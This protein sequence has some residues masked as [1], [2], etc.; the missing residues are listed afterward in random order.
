VCQVLYAL[1]SSYKNPVSFIFYIYVPNLHLELYFT[2]ICSLCH[3][4]FPLV[5]GSCAVTWCDTFVILS[6][7]DPAPLM[8][9]NLL[10]HLC[11]CQAYSLDLK[12]HIVYQKYSLK[13][14]INDIVTDLDVSHRTVEQVLKMWWDTGEVVPKVPGKKKKRIRVMLG[15]EMEVQNTYQINMSPTLSFPPH[16][17]F[18]VALVQHY[19]DLYLNELQD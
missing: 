1:S 8:P 15:E 10:E 14:K 18:V 19:L 4:Q 7:R 17:Q 9:R 3:T 5:C 12:Q 11:Q 16:S 2:T 6:S 13:K